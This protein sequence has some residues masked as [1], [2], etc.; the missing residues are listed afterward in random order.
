MAKTYAQGDVPT[1]AMAVG[2]PLG[3]AIG[4]TLGEP[5]YIGIG[6]AIGAGA[7]L[8]VGTSIEA[9]LKKKDRIRALTDSERRLRRR[10][11][12]VG[13]AVGALLLVALVAVYF[14]RA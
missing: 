6:V 11:A 5:A 1:I 12:I 2:M 4:L 7:G 8:A 3:V 9:D 14:T 13:V 10:F